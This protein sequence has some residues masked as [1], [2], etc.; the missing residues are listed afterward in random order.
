M[1]LTDICIS[2]YILQVSPSVDVNP[3]ATIETADQECQIRTSSVVGSGQEASFDRPK[4]L[5][6]S[7]INQKDKMVIK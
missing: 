5:A 6:T 7:M 1:Q 3:K 4:G 2:L